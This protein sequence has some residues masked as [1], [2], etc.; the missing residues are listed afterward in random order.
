VRGV[1]V[2][3]ARKTSL[4]SQ[5]RLSIIRSHAPSP[6]TTV[7]GLPAYHPLHGDE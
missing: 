5:G 1:T 7:A 6:E 3:S 4:P 2:L